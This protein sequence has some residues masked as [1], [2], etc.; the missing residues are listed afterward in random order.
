LATGVKRKKT[1]IINYQQL[2]NWY[3]IEQ[4]GVDENE[5]PPIRTKYNKK[6]SVEKITLR[7]R[8][9]SKPKRIRGE[10]VIVTDVFFARVKQAR[11]HVIGVNRRKQCAVLD[12]N[13]W[14]RGDSTGHHTDARRDVTAGSAAE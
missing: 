5:N 3:R 13:D 7:N 2:R 1:L 12:N 6:A 9:Y 8:K 4:H 14:Q 11:V 10:V